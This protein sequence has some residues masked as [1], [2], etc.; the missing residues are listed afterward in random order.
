[1]AN[2]ISTLIRVDLDI[3]GDPQGELS[4]AS[5]LLEENGFTALADSL[6]KEASHMDFLS[7]PVFEWGGGENSHIGHLYY[8]HRAPL[9]GHSHWAYCGGTIVIPDKA[10]ERK[11]KHCLKHHKTWEKLIKANMLRRLWRKKYAQR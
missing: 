2:L 7:K 1:M 8:T 4:V 11:C 10:Y 6:R 9:Y 3:D 5:D